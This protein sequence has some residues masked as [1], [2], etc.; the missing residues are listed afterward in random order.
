MK[1]L[2][3][4]C[5][6]TVIRDE[7]TDRLTLVNLIDAISTPAFPHLVGSFSIV[8]IYH[9]NEGEP[10]DQLVT[11]RLENNGNLISEQNTHVYFGDLIGNRTITKV[12]G[13]VIG[14]PG[15]FS[16]SIHQEDVELGRWEIP[17]DIED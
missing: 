14:E 7:D 4:A 3:L 13:L 9:I 1:V 16:V 6:E 2:M 10:T 11:V 15:R 12:N 5:A 17:V 8:A